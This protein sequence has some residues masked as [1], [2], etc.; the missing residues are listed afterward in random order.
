MMERKK[1]IIKKILLSLIV[2]FALMIIKS[3]SSQAFTMGSL[4]IHGGEGISAGPQPYLFGEYYCIDHSLPLT[5]TEDGTKNS[6]KIVH[7]NRV[8]GSYY[9]EQITYEE[10]GTYEVE[11]SIA[12][13]YLM[14]T[15]GV[16]SKVQFQNVVWTSG[17][18]QGKPGY[19]NNLSNFT[20]ATITYTGNAMYS[21]VGAWAN[22]Y[23]NILQVSGNKVLI[24]TLPTSEDDLRVF[25]DQ[26]AR[27]YT[28]GPYMINLVDSSG[29]I[30]NDR[31]TEYSNG[32]TLGDLV[33]N[34]ILGVNDGCDSFK[35]CALKRQAATVTYADGSTEENANVIILDEN[36]NELQF[37]KFGQIFYLQIEIP[38]GGEHAISTIEPNFYIE[39]LTKIPGSSIRYY[40]RE[41]QYE[42]TVDKAE[43]YTDS[44]CNTD[45]GRT[46]TFYTNKTIKELYNEG[47]NTQ[48]D[49]KNYLVNLI[50]SQP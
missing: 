47:V 26:S 4:D 12:A 13:G 36:G 46:T 6:A 30:L 5:R 39:Y 32:Q 31:S 23:Y 33:R 9:N 8:N 11:Q 37:P 27:T 45:T 18:W 25:V 22:F 38:E 28:Q 7:F 24:D 41:L 40:A 3:I 42:I 10:S 20:G 48:E 49:L 16:G 21:R 19:V 34:E 15:N 17:V 50:L 1:S 43:E 35:F 29:N 14:Y 2:I 44:K